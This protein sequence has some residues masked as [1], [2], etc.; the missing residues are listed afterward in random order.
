MT[1]TQAMSDAS[2]KIKWALGLL[3]SLEKLR[4][5]QVNLLNL[6]LSLAL[7]SITMSRSDHL[8]E[9]VKSDF[10]TKKKVLE[11]KAWGSLCMKSLLSLVPYVPQKKR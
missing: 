8:R 1:L 6:T 9:A 7:A 5:S 4:G 10:D 3:P 2:A 11:A